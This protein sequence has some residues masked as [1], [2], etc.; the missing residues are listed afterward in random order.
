LYGDLLAAFWLPRFNFPAAASKR[1][2][3]L[4]SFEWR[5]GLMRVWR[6]ALIS[7]AAAV[8]AVAGCGGGGNGTINPT[9]IISALSPAQITAGSQLF[10]LT[11]TGNG[12][13]TTSQ[14]FWNGSMRTTSFNVSTGQLEVSILDG[15]VANPTVALVTV[16]NPAPGGG[17]SAGAS[18]QVNAQQ[19]GGP[20]IAGVD[21]FSPSSVN[22]GTAGPFMLTVNGSNFLPGGNVSWN[23]AFRTSAFVSASMMTATLT[24][25]DLALPGSGSV[26]V[27]NPLADGGFVSSPS[28]N[29][30]INSAA[31]VTPA[32]PLVASFD[33]SHGALLGSG[34]T[35]AGPRS[36]PLR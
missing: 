12:F 30:P 27:N 10:T 21:P 33:F 3:D 11:L 20:L 22:A 5:Q 2:R 28:V 23:G 32:Q 26:A 16:M 19:P 9:P 36:Y 7:A 24:T 4:K 18:F 35:I 17:V 13:V 6:T 14:A 29:F 34:A 31:S 25:E 15:D 1:L 8:C